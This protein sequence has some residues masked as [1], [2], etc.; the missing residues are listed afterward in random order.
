M[1]EHWEETTGTCSL[2]ETFS[3]FAEFGQTLH[4]VTERVWVAKIDSFV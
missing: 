1:G 4:E 2:K 3:T